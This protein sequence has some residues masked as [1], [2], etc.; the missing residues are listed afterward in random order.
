[1]LNNS[2]NNVIHS[3]LEST[4][5]ASVCLFCWNNSPE[6]KDIQVT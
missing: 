2:E 1:M 4:M 5:T 3:F 6:V